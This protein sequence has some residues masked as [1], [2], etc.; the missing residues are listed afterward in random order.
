M[1]REEL[2]NEAKV[3]FGDSG[4]SAAF[5][6]QGAIKDQAGVETIKAMIDQYVRH[7]RW[8]LEQFEAECRRFSHI[9]EEEAQKGTL[10]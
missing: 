2:F 1:T 10:Y 5:Q 3:L 4:V 9:I 7:R 8:M 6:N